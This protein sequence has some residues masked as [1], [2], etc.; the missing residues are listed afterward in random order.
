ME[1]HE[2]L[3]ARFDQSRPRLRAV[4]YRML[5][6][7]ADADDAVQEAWI[8][9]SRTDA[10]GIENLEGWLT[11][12]VARA[13]LNALHS[14]RLRREESYDAHVPD[15]IVRSAAAVDPEQ[16]AILADSVSLA[17]LVVLERLTPAERLAFVL[18]DM[19]D[20]PF[21]EIA[22]IVGRTPVAARQLASR[23]RRA[24]KGLAP[25][26]DADL[27]RQREVVDAFL[28]AAHRGDFRGLLEVLDPGVV[29]RADV[30]AAP[31]GA[32][33]VVRGA[34]AVAEQA[35]AFR[36]LG[37]FARPVLVNGV[38]GF[39]AAPGGH[40]VSVLGFTVL[41][42]RIVEIDILADP[43]RLSQ[44]DLVEVEPE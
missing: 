23:A 39:I 36:Q 4:A 2:W 16:E 13:C 22:P 34:A 8:R 28:A 27:A 7:I 31:L 44:L 9:L 10:N 42:G 26:P 17:L 1:D 40:T 19:F 14:R 21:E 5:G 33:R 38:P 37:T 43:E 12:V 25:T 18:H 15:P 29:L 30:G 11:T 32:S 35:L 6:S 3:A 24:V 20:V 41:G